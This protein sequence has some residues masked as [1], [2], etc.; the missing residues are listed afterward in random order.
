[1]RRF[2][3]LT[4]FLSAGLL[5]LVEPMFARMVLPLAG[6]APEVWN[7][8]LVFF[9]ATLL[10][11]YAWAHFVTDR[12]SPRIQLCLQAALLLFPLAL[13][14]IHLSSRWIPPAGR[15]PIPWIFLLALVSVG[16]AFFVLSTITPLL[17]RWYAGA[18]RA[19]G[20]DPYPLYRASN[21]GSMV[22]LLSYPFFFEPVFGLNEQQ[23]VWAWGYG[24]LVLFVFACAV[25]TW[26]SGSLSA[27]AGPAPAGTAPSADVP[28]AFRQ[29]LRW[30]LLAFVPSSLL[31]GVTLTV[32]TDLPPIPLLWI[33]PLAIY[34]ATFVFVFAE[35]PPLPHRI[36][37][38]RL[39]FLVLAVLF[40]WISHAWLPA[41][42]LLALNWLAFFVAAM[43]C[44]G[45]LAR[46][47]P[48]ASRLTGFYLCLAI[49]GVLGGV[50]NA[51]IAPLIFPSVLE[52]PLMLVAAAL[53]R[54]PFGSRSR[55]RAKVEGRLETKMPRPAPAWV[56]L[57]WAA[58]LGVF[59]LALVRIV[60]AL[61]VQDQT[62]LR[63]GAF[64][65]PLLLCLSFSRR[66][67]RFALGAAALLV[68]FHSYAGPFGASLYAGRNYF[69]VSRVVLSQNGKQA[70]LFHGSTIH[71][72]ENLD[73]NR[74]D[75]P[76]GYYTRSGPIGQVFTQLA[77]SGRNPAVAIIG[78]GVG[79]IAA[80]AQ[81]GQPFTF[82]EIDPLVVRLARDPRYFTFLQDSPGAVR[83]VLGDGRLSLAAAPPKSF[84]LLVVDAFSSD[85]IPVHLLTRQAMLLY[86]AKL[87]PDGILAFNVSNRYLD[88][89][90]VLAN[91]ARNLGLVGWLRNDT[92]V[93][94]QDI[95]QGKFASKWIVLARRADDA[96]GL[97]QD[98]R[99]QP[100]QP[101]PSVGLWTDNYSDLVRI[102][103]WN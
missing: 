93:T 41:V 89:Q 72:L 70:L 88:L 99:W 38:E 19:H 21:L 82:Y 50:F 67:L 103:R 33:V 36:F 32:T 96:S 11:G 87:A 18:K 69:G 53:V 52:Y 45:E 2:F 49:G 28:V 102:I 6:G 59:A 65:P 47:R 75:E 86:L 94:Q 5:F 97:A 1:M 9:Q 68:G 81:P 101:R 95:D 16:P 44:H 85:A 3:G 39:P 14:P 51:L 62:V 91:L 22:A 29:R 37:V 77:A 46:S 60:P 24:G 30:I 56:D 42:V 64:V 79:G 78:L 74:R 12:I 71:G 100:L 92:A 25:F 63:L 8:C 48:P 26:R 10:A 17:Q 54:P 90:P 98:P 57:A 80:Y 84:G 7:T 13:L 66:P 83:V 61:G 73:P 23:R 58:G 31:L 27:P 15:N 34:L 35:R 20:A 4:L 43:V 55:P 76:L 40:V